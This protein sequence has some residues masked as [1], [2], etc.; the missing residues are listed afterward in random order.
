VYTTHLLLFLTW[1]RIQKNEDANSIIIKEEKASKFFSTELEDH[2]FDVV[3]G[4]F[5]RHR[6]VPRH[7]YCARSR[8]PKHQ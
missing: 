8:L 3:D 5:I 2:D 6:A 1:H 4:L 7:R